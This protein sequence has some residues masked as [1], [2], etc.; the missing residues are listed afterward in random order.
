LSENYADEDQVEAL[1]A[2]WKEYGTA[3]IVGV[4]SGSLLISGYRYWNYYKTTQSEKASAIYEKIL[5]DVSVGKMDSA[6]QSTQTL[7]SDYTISP[8]PAISSLM[9]ANLYI[10]KKNYGKAKE[11][12][13]STIDVARDEAMVHV[14]RLRL[15]RILFSQENN[16]KEALALIDN[17][18]TN[19]FS[20][21]YNE[22]KGDIHMS[23]GNTAEAIMSY[24]KALA[25][26]NIS[27]DYRPVM[28]MKLDNAKS[29]TP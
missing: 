6:D 23:T 22:L 27:G 16:A 2:W 11:Y 4:V 9:L 10:E 26:S 3:V 8:Y 24:N 19:G 5:N 7:L 29:K 25:G 18:E 12:L 14:A 21:Q 13:A 28:Q 15:A 1:K 20:S 17:K